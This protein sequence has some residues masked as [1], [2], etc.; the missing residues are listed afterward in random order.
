MAHKIDREAIIAWLGPLVNEAA[1][2]NRTLREIATVIDESFPKASSELR[3][4]SGHISSLINKM[5]LV[6]EDRV[7]HE[8]QDHHLAKETAQLLDDTIQRVE[9]LEASTAFNREWR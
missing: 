7:L 3:A 5:E 2:S 8:G 6:K 1:S 4:H 9:K